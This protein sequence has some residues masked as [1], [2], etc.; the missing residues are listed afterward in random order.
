[1]GQHVIKNLLKSK[2]T[3]KQIRIFTRNPSGSECRKLQKLGRGKV[4]LEKGNVDNE[5]SLRAA[6][7]GAHSIFCNTNFWSCLQDVWAH[8]GKLGTDPWPLYRMAEDTDVQQGKLILELARQEGVEHFVFSSL[9]ATDSPSGGLFPAPHFDAK[10][11]VEQFIN[12]QRQSVRWYAEH[13]TIF[14]T[15]PYMENF[16]AGRMFRGGGDRAAVRLEVVRDKP[17][18][19]LRVP[20]GSALWPMV[21]LN[22]IGWFAAQILNHEQQW[23]GRTLR[24]ISDSLPIQEIGKIFQ[25]VTGIDAVFEPYTLSEYKA[26]NQPETPALSNMFSFIERF[27]LSRDINMLRDL[28]PDL[29]TFE[30]WLRTSGWRGEV[31]VVQK[32]NSQPLTN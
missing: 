30:T 15:A 32:D 24:I 25:S 23:R 5:A 31:G 2:N 14:V 28:H 26:I 20:I 3:F 18:L 9:D 1:M 19:L 21:T 7:G 29:S 12:E 4:K 8:H 22:D 6:I 11:R 17:R 27:G 16:K 10:A 13:V